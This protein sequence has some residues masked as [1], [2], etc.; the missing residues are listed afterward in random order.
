[1]NSLFFRIFLW[2]WL[3]IAVLSA[4]LV[5]SAAL[6]RSSSADR[7]RWRQ[8]NE[9]IL[10]LR[11][12]RESELLDRQGLAVV[13]SELGTLEQN[14]S[15]RTYIFDE[16]E[17]EVLKRTIPSQ[18]RSVLSM[19]SKSG[20]GGPQLFAD[21]SIGGE[22]VVGPSGRAYFFILSFPARPIL[23]RSVSRILLDEVGSEGVFYLL[24]VLAIAGFFC[25]WLARHI[26]H[27]IDKLRSAARQMANDNL[28][29]RVDQEVLRRED[30]IAELGQ[31]FDRMADRIN[32]L[33][34][35]HRR[36]LR[37]VSHE[38]RSPLARLNIALGLARHDANPEIF[39]HLDRIELETNR[40]NELIGE[41]LTLA[42]ADSGVDLQGKKVFDLGALVQEV[43][44]D[45]NYE[46]RS[47]NCTVTFNPGFEC[48]VEGVPEMLRGA[49]ENVVRNAVR[50]TA[51]G[52][53]VEIALECR[54]VTTKA[55]ALIQ[56][57]D[58]GPGIPT[59]ELEKIFNPFHRVVNG[60]RTESV[61]TGLGLAITKRTFQLC[62]GRVRAANAPDGGL[63][64]TLELPTVNSARPS[65]A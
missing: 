35:A 48:M 65:L 37:D 63:V 22:K 17:H 55:S 50:H 2:F 36:L 52:T 3:A 40:L 45:S 11:A 8:R 10:D 32:T 16:D 12:Q 1:M 27:P 42:R 29:V 62:G 14:D 7:V 21:G 43:A 44:A 25:Y 19:L 57:R 9:L 61:G 39:E 28:K 18:I 15:P 23:P 33:V 53:D 47:R 6:L 51:E 24:A 58:H 34:T 30:E 38:L 59:Q 13:L 4:M 5:I 26:T 56:V 20:E 41:L 64:I 54:K 31:D 49:V 60:E 46:A